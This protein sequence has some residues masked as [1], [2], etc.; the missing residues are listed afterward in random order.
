MT[1]VIEAVIAEIEEQ[2]PDEARLDLLLESLLFVAGEPAQVNK[3]ATALAVKPSQIEASLVRLQADYQVRGIRL[4]RHGAAVQLVSAPEASEAIEA[5]LGLDLTTRLSRAALEALSIIAYR[6]PVT[7]PQLEAIRG[8]NCDGVLRTL[9]SRGLVEEVGRLEQAGRPILYGT[10]FEFLQYFGITA[11][12]ELPPLEEEAMEQL[13]ERSQIAGAE[14]SGP[15]E[16]YFDEAAD[17]A[18]DTDG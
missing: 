15:G 2:E 10:T 16:D 18:D 8:V 6:Q 1:E 3:L 13:A 11:L 17:F 14:T 7:R 5:Y 9:L 4:Q 12:D